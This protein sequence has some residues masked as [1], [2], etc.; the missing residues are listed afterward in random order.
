MKSVSYSHIF[1]QHVQSITELEKKL[2]ATSENIAKNW[3]D[4][5]QKDFYAKYTTRL[6]EHVLNLRENYQQMT[7]QI[8]NIENQLNRYK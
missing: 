6:N 4:Q 3:R 8:K 7:Q 5:R 1:N 2:S